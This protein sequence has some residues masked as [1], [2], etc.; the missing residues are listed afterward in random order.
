MAP[1]SG[2]REEGKKGEGKKECEG[3]GKGGEGKNE[4]KEREKQQEKGMLI[5]DRKGRGGIDRD[6]TFLFHALSLSQI[7]WAYPF[8][9][10]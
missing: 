3:K 6:G 5:E 8:N 7:Q 9:L 1:K 4:W 2:K 10:T